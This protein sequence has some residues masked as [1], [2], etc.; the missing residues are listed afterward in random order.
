VLDPADLPLRVTRGLT[1]EQQ[2][3]NT[4]QTAITLTQSGRLL[5]AY[6]SLL[7][8]LARNPEAHLSRETLG[9]ILLAQRE[10]AQA[11][12]VVDEGLQLAPNYSPYKKIKSRLLMLE[13]RSADALQVLQQ[14]PP[15]LQADQEYHE[16]LATLFQQ[17]GQH[18]QA[19]STY[20]ELLRT[21]GAE[22]RW[23]AGMGI[24]LEAQGDAA[25]ALASYQAAL[26]QSSLDASVRQYSQA[27]V[28]AL[29]NQ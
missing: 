15:T 11:A 21:N 27:R 13:G 24:S 6:E 10:Y 26:Q 17:V 7:T 20:Q 8:F 5:E 25:K 19:I 18:S 2:D 16:L 12:L 14:L 1:V 23:W 28:Q 3:R 9:T 22:G 4:S 29:S